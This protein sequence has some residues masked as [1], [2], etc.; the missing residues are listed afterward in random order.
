VES[1]SKR[2]AKTKAYGTYPPGRGAMKARLAVSSV[3]DRATHS[4]A[5]R[6]WSHRSR[7]FAAR[8]SD[9]LFW[10]PTGRLRSNF[11]AAHFDQ[12]D[13]HAQQLRY[14]ENV[15]LS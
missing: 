15:S 5:P 1:G 2:K 9:S 8:P 3:R 13:S 11:V 4:A 7:S 12:A 6:R 14:P 10:L